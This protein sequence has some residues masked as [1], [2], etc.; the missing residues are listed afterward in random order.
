MSIETKVRYCLEH[1]TLPEALWQNRAQLLLSFLQ[2]KE[3]VMVELYKQAEKANPEYACPY[4]AEQFTVCFREY[5]EDNGSVLILK[6]EMPAP[7]SSPLCRA[8]YICFAGD[9]HEDFYF[10]SELA[11]TGQYY[12]CAHTA[13]KM[14]LKFDE[15]DNEFDKVAELFWEMNRNGG[16]A[17]LKSLCTGTGSLSS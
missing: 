11:S 13:N 5:V 3:Q 8:I 4:S 16:S 15:A 1:K 6:V 14:H 7:E 2:G 10:T 9:Q 12:L 17:R